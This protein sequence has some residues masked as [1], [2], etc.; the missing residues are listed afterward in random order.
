MKALLR[1]YIC[2]RHFC[3]WGT[4]S[5]GT[6]PDGYQPRVTHT[7]HP[8]HDIPEHEI[9]YIVRSPLGS[10]RCFNGTCESTAVILVLP[11]SYCWCP[12]GKKRVDWRS[13]SSYRRCY[14]SL[15]QHRIQHHTIP[16]ISVSSRCRTD[17]LN[18][19]LY[20]LSAH[21]NLGMRFLAI[22]VYIFTNI[23]YEHQLDEWASKAST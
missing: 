18:T 16:A 4:V 20:I 17:A 10:P 15:D 22:C 11:V 7:F 5:F 1:F 23:F 3:S 21:R 19:R 8:E 6:T 2:W 13:I 14:M 9:P 12:V